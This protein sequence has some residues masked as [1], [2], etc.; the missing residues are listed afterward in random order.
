M[1]PYIDSEISNLEHVLV[2]RP[3]LSIQRLTPNNY[4]ELLFDDVLWVQEAQAEHHKF[5]QLLTERG[6]QVHFVLDLLV[7]A[8]GKPTAASWILDRIITTF[9]YGPI[10]QPILKGYLYHLD[11]NQLASYLIGGI[12]AKE[13]KLSSVSLK[14]LTLKNDDFLLLPLPNFLFT[15]DSSTWI[16]NHLSLNAMASSVRQRETLIIELIYTQALF[17]KE[18]ISF[19]YN[20]AEK[21]LPPLEGG[22]IMV[23]SPSCILIGLSQRTAP[24]AIEIFANNLFS[25]YPQCEIFV[26]ELPNLRSTLHLD[27]V[28]TMVDEGTFCGFL[29]A[30]AEP[31]RFWKLTH[32]DNHAIAIKP[33]DDLFKDLARSLNVDKIRIISLEGTESVS[34]REQWNDS[35]NLLALAPGV[36]ISYERN[37]EMNKKLRQ[38]GIEV[39]EI[40]GGELARGRGGPHCMSAPLRRKPL[41]ATQS[42]KEPQHERSPQNP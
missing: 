33:L 4:K 30:L 18:K 20:G 21:R 6:V 24:Q 37:F 10:L 41:L 13:L 2:H 42:I 14:S 23:I 8:L 39:L 9:D 32:E 7:E 3:G 1:Q 25:F 34:W 11:K 35:N 5:T 38:A 22:D 26:I 28:L 19:I 40:P 29:E 27:T 36:V 15:R 17:P 12:K 16:F 31:K